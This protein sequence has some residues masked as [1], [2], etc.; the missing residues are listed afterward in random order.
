MSHATYI[1]NYSDQ[2]IEL[3]FD[4]VPNYSIRSQLKNY[5]WYWI[6]EKMCWST[7]L[8]QS[9]ERQAISIG[10]TDGTLPESNPE[11]ATD[12]MELN[13]IQ[14]AMVAIFK[15]TVFKSY[16]LSQINDYLN[17]LTGANPK[18]VHVNQVGADC[19][20]FILA[21]PVNLKFATVGITNN[22]TL[23]NEYKQIFDANSSFAETLI[24]NVA[25]ARPYVLYRNS[26]Y[27]IIGVSDT[28]YIRQVITHTQQLNLSYS[29]ADIWVYRFKRPCQKHNVQS[30]TAYI[31]SDRSLIEQ[32]INVAYCP[33]CQ[34]YYINADQYRTFIHRNG[35]PYL[36]LK[37]FIQPDYASWQKESLL[38]YMGYNVNTVDNLSN[39][40][41]WH[42]LEH[43]IDTKAMSKIEVISFLEFLIHQNGNNPRF[44]KAIQ[45]WK[46]DVQ[47][48][49]NY[50]IREQKYIRGRLLI[51]I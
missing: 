47:Y 30:V 24:R 38:H 43:A 31:A 16:S 33:V 14:A 44:A 37:S 40:D 22:S 28:E 15:N 20:A 32:P 2:K 4:S 29:Y 51:R 26:V 8:S 9:A 50:R 41:R 21:D 49:R 17:S 25:Y 6:A 42:I 23:A 35:L 1:K 10:A 3:Y 13:S 5:G 36:R 46:I 48:I 45:K 7:C 27:G 39:H 18:F 11:I 19:A 12:K 34:R